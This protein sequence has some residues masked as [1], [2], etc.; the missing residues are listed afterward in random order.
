M[1]DRDTSTNDIDA[2]RYFSILP[3]MNTKNKHYIANTFMSILVLLGGNLEFIYNV[4]I[5]DI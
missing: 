2:S 5:E 1:N 4:D 3:H